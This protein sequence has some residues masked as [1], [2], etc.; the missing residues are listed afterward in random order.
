LFP[1][2]KKYFIPLFL[3]L[4]T[5]T[6]ATGFYQH[7]LSLSDETREAAIIVHMNKEGNYAIPIF[8]NQIFV[9]KPP[10]YYLE[11]VGLLKLN[12]DF[13][14]LTTTLRLGSLLWGIGTL[15]IAF[16]LGLLWAKH[17]DNSSTKQQ[18]YAGFMVVA[19]LAS[20]NA[21]ISNSLTIRTDIALTF[22]TTL[23]AFGF[24]YAYLSKKKT[25]SLIAALGVAGGFLTKG[26]IAVGLSGLV[27]LSLLPFIID[28]IKDR[29]KEFL[30]WHLLIPAIL[31][32]SLTGT[33]LYFLIAQ[34]GLEA[35]NAWFME[36]SLRRVTGGG[37]LGH[38][39]PEQYFYYIKHFFAYSAPWCLIWLW[40]LIKNRQSL[41]SRYCLPLQLWV[42]L[43]LLF[44]SLVAT[45][46]PVYVLP[47]LP[48][49]AIAVTA[50]WWQTQTKQYFFYL[51]AGVLLIISIV[52][53]TV[54]PARNERLSGH[55]ALHAFF[56]N[57]PSDAWD[58][59]IS[60]PITE[61]MTGYIYTFYQKVP[62][63]VSFEEFQEIMKGNN[64]NGYR[65]A[66][67]EMHGWAPQMNIAPN[68]IVSFLEG[69]D[70][71][72]YN[73]LYLIKLPKHSES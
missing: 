13:F 6:F 23:S 25:G 50:S 63:T 69:T 21:F 31:V 48:F 47:L 28:C 42:I 35:W 39:H 68:Q 33:W 71:T 17:W 49:L 29:R 45:K 11:Q 53:L 32:I 26:I 62:T 38:E 36:N 66:I 2:V 44:L 58:K 56:E 67:V 27:W 24:S 72:K 43:P 1:Q 60:T 7:D 4:L 30:L 65:Y 9:E 40:G 5:A 37:E 61:R 59:T 3:L 20:C 70:D 64:P 57:E 18:Y 54:L 73:S 16:F 46:R 51:A 8:R 15:C 41:F 22:F 12:H 10:L 34:G 14:S 52:N 55:D 19:I